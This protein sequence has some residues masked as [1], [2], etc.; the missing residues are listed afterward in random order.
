MTDMFRT[1]V[2]PCLGELECKDKHKL[3]ASALNARLLEKAFFDERLALFML[4]F[5]FELT[6]VTMKMYH[7]GVQTCLTYMNDSCGHSNN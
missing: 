7:W 1:S 3:R 2:V 6:L 4:G 5:A